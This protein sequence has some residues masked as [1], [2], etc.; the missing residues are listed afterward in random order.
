[1]TGQCNISQMTTENRWAVSLD[2]MS[3]INL[4]YSRPTHKNT[5]LVT[6]FFNVEDRE[7]SATINLSSMERYRLGVDSEVRFFK[8]KYVTR[9]NQQM[10]QLGNDLTIQ[11]CLQQSHSVG[12]ND[13]I[14]V[15]YLFK[16][17]VP[18]VQRPVYGPNYTATAI[19]QPRDIPEMDLIWA[20]YL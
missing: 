18:Q 7:L 14:G 2:C 10:L 19:N 6:T 4:S 8:H 20:A 1:M 13:R 9:R 17:G 16:Q 11:K 5:K 15:L 3:F 12:Q